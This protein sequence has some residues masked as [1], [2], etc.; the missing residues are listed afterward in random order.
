MIINTISFGGLMRGTPE[1]DQLR[2]EDVGQLFQRHGMEIERFLFRRVACAETAADLTQEAFSRLLQYNPDASIDNIR[3]FLFKIA[4]NLAKDHQRK[5]LR[6]KTDGVSDDVLSNVPDTAP[7]AEV[8]VADKQTL[9]VLR[10]AINDLPPKTRQIF[11]LARLDGLTYREVALHLGI[12]ESSV[13][14]H[15]ALALAHAMAKL[16]RPGAGN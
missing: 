4:S 5:I 1:F 14:K 2:R 11:V 9:S 13:Q 3:A 10:A 15:L 12:S 8:Q 6:Q 7:D 16:G